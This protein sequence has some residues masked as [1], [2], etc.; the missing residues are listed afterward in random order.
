MMRGY[1]ELRECR[2]R[3]ILNY[4]GEDPEWERCD[5]S[6]VDVRQ[7][8]AN[9]QKGRGALNAYAMNDRVEHVTLGHGIVQR[10]TGDTLTVL[11]DS[12]GG[13]SHSIPSL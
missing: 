4:F 9:S 2:R 8:P 7:T 6:D 3:Y 1:A 11:F 12:G 10:V 5:R 13:T